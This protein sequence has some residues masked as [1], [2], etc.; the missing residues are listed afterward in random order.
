MQ[1]VENFHY[2]TGGNFHYATGGNF[3]LCNWWKIFQLVEMNYAC[4]VP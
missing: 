2:A 3:S 4:P 1:L